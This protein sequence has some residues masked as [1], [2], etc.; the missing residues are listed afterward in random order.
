MM[1]FLVL[2]AI[3]AG[4]ASLHYFSLPSMDS[5]PIKVVGELNK[6]KISAI[7]CAPDL[8]SLK[9]SDNDVAAMI[10]LPGTGSHT[11]NI[12]SSN[13]SARYYFNQGMNLYYGFHII[14]AIPSFKKAIQFDPDAAILHWA[15]ALAYGPNIN[16]LGYAAS[17]GALA[18]IGK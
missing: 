2:T 11:W 14:E 4:L 16:D 6:R 13:D 8:N 9:F 17:P 7:S 1:K 5:N 15:E 12:R 3:A 18:A 10:P